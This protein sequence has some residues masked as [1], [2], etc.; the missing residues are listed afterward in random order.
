MGFA[1]TDPA[2]HSWV[3]AFRDAL[4]K[5]GWAEGS[6]LRLELRWAAADPERIMT[7]A[8]E[9]VVLRPDAI[10]DQ[11]T[12]ST[13]PLA[14]RHKQFRLSSS[15]SPIQHIVGGGFGGRAAAALLT[16]TAQRLIQLSKYDVNDAFDGP[17]LL[18]S[19]QLAS[20]LLQPLHP[21]RRQVR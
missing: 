8:K 12:P 2:A 17:V 5:L 21:V 16:R 6:N 4:A 11:T 3:K 1:Q 18:I 20:F 7:L 13:G 9:L 15:T 19:S 10:F 14:P